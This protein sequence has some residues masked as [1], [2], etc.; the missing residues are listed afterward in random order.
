MNA[1]KEKTPRSGLF[2]TST[3]KPLVVRELSNRTT[4]GSS[5]MLADAPPACCRGCADR[6]SVVSSAILSPGR[7]DD[8]AQRF[9][10]TNGLAAVSSATTG[11]RQVSANGIVST[12]NAFGDN[13]T[14]RSPLSTQGGV[15]SSIVIS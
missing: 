1:P 14:F 6:S 4:A 10:R 8:D 3:S 2:A 12:A 5:L 9:R 7:A 11:L 13:A 15:T